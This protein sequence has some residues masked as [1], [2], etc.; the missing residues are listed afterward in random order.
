[1]HIHVKLP[2]AVL[3]A[4]TAVKMTVETTFLLSN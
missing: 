4:H 2:S 1:M 3:N